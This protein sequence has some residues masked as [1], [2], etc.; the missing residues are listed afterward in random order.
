M[1]QYLN[2]HARA[3]HTQSARTFRPTNIQRKHL[4]TPRIAVQ[5]DIYSRS[6]SSHRVLGLAAGTGLLANSHSLTSVILHD[7]HS[8]HARPGGIVLLSIKAL[9]RNDVLKG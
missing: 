2:E 5:A 6:H 4:G 7:E 8:I 1:V 3:L 9:H